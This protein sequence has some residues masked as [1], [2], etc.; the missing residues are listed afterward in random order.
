VKPT[1]LVFIL[2]D[3]HRRDMLGCYGNPVVRT[4][5][6]D[7]LAARGARFNAAYTNCPI[8]V[9]A[10]ASLATGQ[11]VHQIGYWD[12]AF[13]YEGA[14][15]GWGHELRAAGHR[16]ESIGKL[17]FRGYE[18]D[19]VGFGETHIPLNVV[20]GVG[21]V[22]GCIRDDDMP[23][24]DGAR[25]SILNAG[26]G[27]STYLQYDAGIADHAVEWLRDAATRD[28]EKPWVLFVSFVCPHPPFVAPPELYEHYYEA[29]LPAPVQHAREER[30]DHP[31]LNH[32]RR[33]FQHEEPYT[34]NELRSVTAAYYGTSEFLDQQVGK[35]VDALAASGQDDETRVLYTSDHGESL[36]SRGLF[37]KFTMYEESAGVPLIVAGPDIPAGVVN[38]D[39]VS[40]VDCY[41]TIVES[42]GRDPAP[43]IERP[44][45]S[46]LPLAAGDT[47]D[48]YA[49]CEYHAVGSPS[50]IYMLRDRRH[51]YVHYVGYPA[52]LFDLEADPL[53]QADLAHDPGN[54]DILARLDAALREVLDPLAVDTHA[55]S[56]QTHLVDSYGGPEAVVARGTF[57]NSPAPGEAPTYHTGLSHKA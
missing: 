17:H 20:D 2:S 23:V 1:N 38:D 42:V 51:K 52:Q 30:P 24:R 28:D 22:M 9:P 48:G 56:D 35:V 36:G 43:G 50:A 16:V 13:P 32:F 3:Q 53:E 41:D 45:S 31:V 46:L 4:P 40:L 39:P 33:I 26:P 44:G 27:D 7:A 11:Y 25:D 29:D 21:D 37:G 54:A 8:C 57:T 34:G 49:F 14:V 18:D 6:L 15:E 47:R 55:K 10:R 12:N 19:D 5:N